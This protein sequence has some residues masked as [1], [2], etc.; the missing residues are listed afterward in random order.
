MEN[1]IRLQIH[2]FADNLSAV[3]NKSEDMDLSEDDTESARNDVI[4]E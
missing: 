2:I 1:M 3:R 4:T